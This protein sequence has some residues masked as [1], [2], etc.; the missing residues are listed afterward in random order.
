MA[1]CWKFYCQHK[2]HFTENTE[3]LA[4]GLW[5]RC[6]FL[7]FMLC[8]DDF[9]WNFFWL[10]T[11]KFVNENILAWKSQNNK[12]L[13]Q[14]LPEVLGFEPTIVLTIFFCTV[15]MFWLLGELLPKN[16][17]IYCYRM[18]LGTTNTYCLMCCA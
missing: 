10:F 4:F 13:T 2:I 12:F 18:K 9:V 11:V 14:T 8:T 15:N 16:Y 17:P 3:R 5:R 7:I 1:N 6:I